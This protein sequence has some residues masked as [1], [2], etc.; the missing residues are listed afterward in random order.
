MEQNCVDL[1]AV[2]RLP[3]L[4]QDSAAG[5]VSLQS[6]GNECEV[7]KASTQRGTHRV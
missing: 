5:N 6:L 2:W 3:M 7:V 1:Q 4:Q